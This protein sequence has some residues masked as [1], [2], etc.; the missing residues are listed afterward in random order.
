ARKCDSISDRV[1]NPDGDHFS[2][3]AFPEW[4]AVPRGEAPRTRKIVLPNFPIRVPRAM[5]CSV[6]PC[7]S[8]NIPLLGGVPYKLRVLPTPL[9]TYH[10]P[11]FVGNEAGMEMGWLTGK[12]KSFEYSYLGSFSRWPKIIVVRR[13]K[14]SRDESRLSSLTGWA[15]IA[16][17]SC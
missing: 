6:F 7:E 2:R 10:N 1:E 11:P 17:H 14:K 9:W 15:T 13:G 16:L 3:C 4:V 5:P 12:V 8:P